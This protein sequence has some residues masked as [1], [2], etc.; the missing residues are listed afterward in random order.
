MKKKDTMT[1]N[2]CNTPVPHNTDS[3][4]SD[5]DEM[6]PMGAFWKDHTEAYE[7]LKALT[8]TDFIFPVKS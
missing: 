7:V 4:D 5:G 1:H 2:I 6:L 3:D 8:V